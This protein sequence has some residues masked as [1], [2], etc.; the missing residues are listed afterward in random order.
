MCMY[1]PGILGFFMWESQQQRGVVMFN[2]ALTKFNLP[3]E[4][5]DVINHENILVPEN[6][7]QLV[8]LA[9]G[10]QQSGF[11]EVAYRV[12][13]KGRVVEAT[14]ARCKNGV[15]IN[16]T[17]P[18]MR[19]R[20]P[21]CMVIGDDRPTDKET[22]QQRF[23]ESFS[24]VRSQTLKWLRQ[25]SLIVMPFM[26]GG[27]DYG[28][29]ALLIAPRN[30]AFFAA[31]L[32]DL[33]EFV[34]RAQIPDDFTPRGIIYAAPPF[35]HTHFDGKQVVVHSRSDELHEVFSYNLYPG[36]SAK[37]GVYS[38][39]L[40][41]GE[42]EGWATLHAS[43][44]KIITP[45]ENILIIMHEGA[46]GG[47]KSEMIEQIHRQ[48]DGSVKIG[49]NVVTG[50]EIVIQLRESSELKP[51]TDDM[52]MCP[53]VLQ[54]G[55]GKLVVKDAEDGWFL[56]IDHISEYGTEPYYEKITIHPKEPLIFLNLDGN[57][58][59]PA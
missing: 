38:M 5:L 53:A 25:Q 7:D 3:K 20:D 57:Q 10:G 39:L 21:D 19:R 33:Q 13:G 30:A 43:T 9:I 51:I 41:I 42:A 27:M 1:S 18:Y 55:N 12:P 6:R 44:V 15:S 24:S 46:S 17:E 35:R 14:V 54:Q 4:I 52:A 16:F 50:E 47:G 49:R 22:Y 59:L 28:Y 23:G 56:R 58:G 11:Y 45:Y 29:P 32:A 26:A 2:P 34:P 48:E 31:A 8:R 40:D 37:K 36:P